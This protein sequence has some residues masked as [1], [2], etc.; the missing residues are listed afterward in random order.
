MWSRNF[1]MVVVGQIISL[2]G[3]AVLRFALPLYLLNETGSAALFGAVSACAFIPMIVLSP[4]GGIFA[5]RVN[6]RNIMVVLDFSTAIL[7]AGVIMLLG[8][9]NL[10]ILLLSTMFL[11]YGIQGAY[12]PAVQASIPALLSGEHIMQGNAVINLVSSFSGLI[13]PVVGGAL[14]SFYGIMPILYVSGICFMSSAVMEMF[15]QIPYKKKQAQGNIFEIGFGDLK[16]SFYY[17]SKKQPLIMKLSLAVAAINMILSA[18]VIIGMPVIITQMLALESEAAS[19]LYGYAEGAMA[20]GSLCGGMGAGIFAGKLKTRNGYMLLFYDALTLI[21]IGITLM[22]PIPAMTAYII[23]LLSCFV[24]MLLATL[25]SIQ[26]MS[27]L[28]IIVPSDLIG[29]VIS[30]AMC[31]GMCASPIGQAIYGALFEGM[32]NSI[33]LVF[34]AVAVLTMLLAFSLKKSFAELEQ[35][36]AN[37]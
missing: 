6:K 19:R 27:Y 34:F 20:I 29:K 12:Q 25:F 28:Q 33:Y 36:I 11:L 15:I 2:F 26:L 4:V 24:M 35:R 31:I 8:K 3:N 16:E 13:G 14:F 37:E 7:V 30:C 22:L 1:L 9:M 5:D 32:R 21:P 10:I 17:M 23:I 18:L